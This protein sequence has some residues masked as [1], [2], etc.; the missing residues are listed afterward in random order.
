MHDKFSV[1]SRSF[2]RSQK[3][4]FL[5][6]DRKCTATTGKRLEENIGEPHM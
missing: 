2:K 3:K 6:F 4:V 1:L 5:S